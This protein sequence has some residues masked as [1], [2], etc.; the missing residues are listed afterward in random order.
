MITNSY[1][2]YKKIGEKGFMRKTVI[3]SRHAKRRMKLY[4]IS[5]KD[6][7]RV[8]NGLKNIKETS[9]VRAISGF[10]YPIKVVFKEENDEII[11]VTAY[12]LKRGENEN[13][14]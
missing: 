3:F 1:V 5:E 11:I 13:F 8:L 10:K 6:V 14:L 9:V 12:P 4:G 7:I 2:H